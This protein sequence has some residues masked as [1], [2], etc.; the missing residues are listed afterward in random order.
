M[1]AHSSKGLTYDNVIIINGMNDLWGF[2]S[3]KEDDPI[4]DLVIKRDNSVE[5]AEERRLF[6]VALTRTSNR[7]FILAPETKPSEFVSELI[8]DK[9]YKNVVVKGVFNESLKKDK[10]YY[11]PDCGFPL[12]RLK[13]NNI[14]IPLYV[15]TNEHELCGFMTNDIKGGRLRVLKCSCLDGYLIVK[16][17]SEENSFFLGCTNYKNDGTGCNETMSIQQFNQLF[18]AGEI[19]KRTLEEVNNRTGLK[20]KGEDKETIDTSK[21]IEE[22]EALKEAEKV[23]REKSQA[24]LIEDNNNLIVSVC[25]YCEKYSEYIRLYDGEDKKAFIK[26]GK[27]WHWFWIDC[28]KMSFCY[29]F[30]HKDELKATPLNKDSL[31]HIYEI[32]DDLIINYFKASRKSL[33]KSDEQALT[34]VA[35]KPEKLKEQIIIDS[36]VSSFIGKRVEDTQLFKDLKEW[37]MAKAKELNVF[38]FVVLSDNAMAQ[39]VINLPKSMDELMKLHGFGKNNCAQYGEQ[40]L[41]IVKKYL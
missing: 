30:T 7:V 37:R 15:C 35:K 38:A 16:K 19:Q 18:P 11:C 2:P 41:E 36:S 4:M 8:L 17:K 32:I 31:A 3:K 20:Y 28:K 14:G 21:A 29:H 33:E 5:Y 34:P 27:S 6:Y 13:G 10:V 12:K 22:A 1:T 40:I 9:G 25:K 24:K 26:N 23:A 39:V